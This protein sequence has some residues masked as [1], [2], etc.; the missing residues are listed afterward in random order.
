MRRGRILRAVRRRR[1]SPVRRFGR[2]LGAIRVRRVLRRVCARVPIA[3][4]RPAGRLPAV[5]LES[6]TYALTASRRNAIRAVR[7][8]RMT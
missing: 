8:V 6:G 5:P 2:R 3:G 4:V 1:V 7:V